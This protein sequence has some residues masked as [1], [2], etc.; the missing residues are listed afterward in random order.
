MGEE[1]SGEESTVIDAT[2]D[3][4]EIVRQGVGDVSL[5]GI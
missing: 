3:S 1:L 2:D 4:I 5:F